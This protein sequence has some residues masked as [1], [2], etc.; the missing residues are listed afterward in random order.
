MVNELHGE[1]IDIVHWSEEPATLVVSALA[2]A[3]IQKVIIDDQ[4]KS[5]LL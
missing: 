3:E 2:P 1:K 4:M 5:V